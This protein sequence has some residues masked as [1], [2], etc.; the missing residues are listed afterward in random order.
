MTSRASTKSARRAGDNRPAGPT[1]LP[2]DAHPDDAVEAMIRVDQAG[3]Y[4]AMRIYAG[5]RAVIRTGEAARE[6]AHMAAQEAEHKAE[7][8]RLVAERQI[9]PTLLQ[10]FWHAAG[11]LLGAGTAAAGTRSAMAC[12]IAVEETI[13]GHYAEQR[14]RLED[15]DREPGLRQRIEA[16]RLEELEHRDIALTHQ[17]RQVA[18]FSVLE[19]AIR[20][21]SKAAIWLSKRI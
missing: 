16:F 17:G 15:W 13:D 9:R 2:G 18:G 20:A 14:D 4:G 11:W 19:T 3:E 6:L 5:Q 7:F 10:P 12:T 1:Y 21:G 8:D